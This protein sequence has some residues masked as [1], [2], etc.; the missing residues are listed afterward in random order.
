MCRLLNYKQESIVNDLY[1]I[2]TTNDSLKG[3][4]GALA[5]DPPI[6]HDARER[7]AEDILQNTNCNVVTV[8]QCSYCRSV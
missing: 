3:M 1:L 2:P 6:F 5:L 7:Q 4:A 8:A